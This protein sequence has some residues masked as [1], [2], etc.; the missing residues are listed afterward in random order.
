[1]KSSNVVGAL[2]QSQRSR[3]TMLD[4]AV[5]STSHAPHECSRIL[6]AVLHECAHT[7][8]TWRP[9]VCYTGRELL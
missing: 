1:M 9:G 6:A 7:R 3:R 8:A 2:G 5:P 4:P